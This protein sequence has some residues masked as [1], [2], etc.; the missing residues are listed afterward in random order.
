MI[1]DKTFLRLYVNAVVYSP[2]QCNE[3]N[4]AFKVVENGTPKPTMKFDVKIPFIER[5]CKTHP[6]FVQFPIQDYVD[7][8]LTIQILKNRLYDYF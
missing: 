4:M 1:N 5:T 2:Y 3:K 7:F 8:G 6:L